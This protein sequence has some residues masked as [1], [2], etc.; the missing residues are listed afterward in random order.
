[1]PD[2]GP[3]TDEQRAALTDLGWALDEYRQAIE[4]RVAATEA[5][6]KARRR[7]NELG[8]QIAGVQ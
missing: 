1:M 6:E 4:R 8:Y 7:L 5:E 3:L 2:L